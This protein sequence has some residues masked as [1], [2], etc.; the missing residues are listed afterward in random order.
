MARPSIAASV[1]EGLWKRKRRSGLGKPG[2]ALTRRVRADSMAADANLGV[3][4][5]AVVLGTAVSLDHS[6]DSESRPLLGQGFRGTPEEIERQW[7]EQVYR[8][9]GDRMA[10]LTCHA[11]FGMP[12]W[13][14]AVAVLLSF[15]LALVACRVTGETDTS[16]SGR[17]ARSPS[18]RSAC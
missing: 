15:A 18:L 8:G 3:R 1:V 13:Q 2:A 16:R 6:P 7:Y 9:R 14:T 12:Y 17:W 10:Q 11:V 5:S 4:S